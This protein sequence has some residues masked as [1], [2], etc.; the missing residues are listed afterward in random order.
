M[1][2]MK[3]IRPTA[4]KGTMNRA[5]RSLSTE[6][7]AGAIISV[8][9]YFARLRYAA[10]ARLV[11]CVS[12]DALQYAA[13]WH[14]QVLREPS[15]VRGGWQATRAGSQSKQTSESRSWLKALGC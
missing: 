4:I 2:G 6:I 1:G 14:Q 11:V 3:Q 13:R 9:Q 10:N 5:K 7:C 12:M 15:L 8:V